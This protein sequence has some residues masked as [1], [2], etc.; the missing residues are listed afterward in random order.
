MLSNMRAISSALRVPPPKPGT[1]ACI[2]WIGLP[3]FSASFHDDGKLSDA[4]ASR[5]P[6][7]PR[8]ISTRSSCTSRA[9]VHRAGGPSSGTARLDTIIA[10]P[11]RR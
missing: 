7:S 6:A 1:G 2:S 11:S 9:A 10:S 4:A 8:R 5:Q 3:N